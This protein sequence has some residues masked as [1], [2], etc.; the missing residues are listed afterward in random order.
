MLVRLPVEYQLLR[1]GNAFLVYRDEFDGRFL[2]VVG[3]AHFLDQFPITITL[4][5]AVELFLAIPPIVSR[6]S[7]EHPDV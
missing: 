6:F 2:E 3:F 1:M 4:L 7:D 5:G